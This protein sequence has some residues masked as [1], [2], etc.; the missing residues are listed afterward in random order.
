M[1]GVPRVSGRHVDAD[2][3]SR[4]QDVRLEDDATHIREW[5]PVLVPGLLQTPAYAEAVTVEGPDYVSPERIAQLVKIRESRQTKIQ[6]GGATYTA[7]VW[8]AVITHP[9]V[10]VDVHREQ[11]S[12][13]LA[14]G[15]RKNVTIQVLPFGAGLMAAASSAFSTFSFDSEPTVEAVTLENLRGASV[16]EAAED[17]AAYAHVYDLLRSSAMAPE[18][19]AKLIRSSLE[20]IKEDTS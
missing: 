16:L 6:E 4:S 7:I 15:T 5:Q 9:L 17:L 18:E 11:L 10:S 19:S 2:G 20:T 8:E 13:M 14:I 12:A 1:A 3:A